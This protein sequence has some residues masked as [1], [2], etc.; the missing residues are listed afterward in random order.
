MSCRGLQKA[1]GMASVNKF[2]RQS[3]LAV[4]RI[5]RGSTDGTALMAFAHS[6][7]RL[8][9]AFTIVPAQQHGVVAA[10]MA[11]DG[12]RQFECGIEIEAQLGRVEAK[13]FYGAVSVRAFSA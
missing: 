5:A 2:R 6:G 1:E 7:R 8:E 10:T 11:S 3:S 12:R 4:E 9:V 13:R